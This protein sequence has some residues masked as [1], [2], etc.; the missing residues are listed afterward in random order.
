MK[1]KEDF[2]KVI[3]EISILY[4]LSL[5]SGQSLDLK[6]SCDLFLKTL[7]AR[8]NLGH[9]SVWIKGEYLFD[10]QELGKSTKGNSHSFFLVYANPEFRIKE[11]V[12][13]P[14]HPIVSILKGKE[15][16]SIASSE[17]GFSEII[18][19]KGID[20]GVFAIFALGKLGLLKLFSMTRETPFHEEQ[21]NQLKNVISKFTISLE[22]CVAHQKVIQEINDRKRA[23][24]ALMRSEKTAK[25]L[26]QESAI[27]AE[28]GR[29]ISSTLN[30]EE[31]YER[32]A[33]A[34]F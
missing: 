9:A 21:L 27:I 16:F 11:K 34:F 13:P 20:R 28:I 2:S 6:T 29:I 7:M 17:N 31:V 12:I 30:I 8:K 22:G 4:E 19:E 15:A 10:L 5:A 18:T 26:A 1:E 32:F 25:R 23:E 14:N 3:S 33:E 24:E